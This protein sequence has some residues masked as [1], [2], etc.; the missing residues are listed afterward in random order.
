MLTSQVSKCRPRTRGD[1]PGGWIDNDPTAASAPH[2]RGWSGL[3]PDRARPGAVGPAPAGMVPVATTSP[4][5]RNGRPRTRGDGPTGPGPCERSGASAPHPRG[6]SEPAPPTPTATGVGP[7]P[8]GM[9]PEVVSTPTLRAGRP[10]TRGDGPR[11]S[12]ARRVRPWSAPHPRGWSPRSSPRRPCGPVG[13]APAGMVLA[14]QRRA[15]SARGRP[16]TRGDGPGQA[17]GFNTQKG[18]A[19]H[20]RGWSRRHLPMTGRLPV[21]P[22]PAGMVRPSAGA[23]RPARRRPRTRGDGPR[24]SSA[25]RRR[26]PSAPHP[27][28]WSVGHHRRRPT[29]RVGPA[30]AGMV[31]RA[32]PA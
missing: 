20:P 10:R 11:R 18:S 13:P 29:R 5:E 25:G 21:G 23:S 3:G 16:R 17:T 32:A 7:A 28:G 27:R 24:A 4:S 12:T 8:A 22:A 2:P 9:V 15:V 31:P 1:G 19:P 6:W 14:G 30:P 26:R